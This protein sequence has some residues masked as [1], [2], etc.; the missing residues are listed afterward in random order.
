[1]AKFRSAKMRGGKTGGQIVDMMKG[2]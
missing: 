2:M 1:M